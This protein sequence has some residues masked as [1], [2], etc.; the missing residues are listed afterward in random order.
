MREIAETA[1]G[2]NTLAAGLVCHAA[3]L[4]AGLLSASGGTA[5]FQ[6][7]YPASWGLLTAASFAQLRHRGIRP[8]ATWRFYLIAAAAV[9]PVLGPLIALALLYSAPAGGSTTGDLT[10]WPAA[11][12]R[13]RAN[14]LLLFVLLLALFL[15][16]A[17]LSRKDD[18]YFRRQNAA[19]VALPGGVKCKINRLPPEAE[20]RL[21]GGVKKDRKKTVSSAVGFRRGGSAGNAQIS[22]GLETM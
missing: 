19:D 7:V 18:P 2:R 21:L 20:D 16:F 17:V 5:F 12:L 4:V 14:I 8:F 6:I 3:A 1:F 22:A 9:F 10:G 13:L 15:L 11:L